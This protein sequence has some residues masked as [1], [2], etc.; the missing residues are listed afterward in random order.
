MSCL[1]ILVNRDD[2][3]GSRRDFF[4]GCPN[5]LAASQACCVTDRWFTPHF[6][7]LARFRIDAWM[8]DVSCP[9]A[10]QPLWPACLLDT[11][12]RSS[13]SSSR[14]VQDVWDVYR[15]VLGVVP[16]EVVLSLRDA[17]TRSAIDDFWSIWR[18]MLRLVYFGLILLLGVLLLL[19]T[20]PFLG[21]V[22]YVFVAGVLE[23]KPL[24]VGVL[25]GCIVFLRVMR[26]IV[27]VPGFL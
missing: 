25:A 13:S 12:D 2:G 8:A 5:A 26:L 27:T 15:D 11:P 14:I 10:C 3:S 23:V 21:G 18:K 9:T 4:I 6:S 1:I 16:G 17:A 20:L 22:P 24:V 7:L 19:A